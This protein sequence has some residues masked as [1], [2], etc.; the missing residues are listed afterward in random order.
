MNEEINGRSLL[1]Y[2]ADYGQSD[3]LSYLI[4]K[5]GSVDSPD[6]HGITPLLAAI[7]EGHTSCVKILIDQGAQKEG[8]CP[9][10]SSYLDAAEKPEIK[11]LLV[12]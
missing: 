3:V 11:A 1:H 10:G 5:G 7:W 9:D 6:K 12:A 8:S 4:G 2:A